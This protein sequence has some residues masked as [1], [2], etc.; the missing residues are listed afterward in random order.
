IER[1]EG[2]GSFAAITSVNAPGTATTIAYIDQ[3]LKASTAYRYRVIAIANGLS[4]SPSSEASVTTLAVTTTGP[5]VADI[6][7]DITTSRT[8]RA[9]T[10]YT[11]KGFI[12]VTNGATMTILPGTVIK[13]DFS[14]LGSSLIVTR[15]AKIKAV[16]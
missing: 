14:I 5:G 6:T 4:S 9:D 7:G 1:S 3:N 2:S 13:G 15:G 12:H 11:L 16:G 10:T 8:L